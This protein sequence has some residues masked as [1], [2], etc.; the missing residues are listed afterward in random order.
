MKILKNY[1]AVFIFTSSLLVLHLR[2]S[3][4]NVGINSKGN[5]PSANAVLDLRTGNR[6]SALGFLPNEVSLSATNSAS[7]F[8][9]PDTG[10]VVYNYATAG[11]APNN[12]VPG[13]YYWTGSAWVMMLA[14]GVGTSGQVLTS[15]GGG[16]P[17][18]TTI[19]TNSGWSLTGNSGTTVG[20]NFI[21][22]TDAQPLEFKVNGQKSGYIDYSSSLANT[23]L[24]YQALSNNTTGLNNTALGYQALQDNTTRANNSAFGAY[25]LQGNT[26]VANSAF[27]SLALY[28]NTS[29]QQNIA[30]GENAG[31]A[32]TTGNYNS[33]MGVFSGITNTT[34]NNNTFIGYSADAASTGLT[35]ATA[36]GYNATVSA[37]NTMVF[38]NNSVTATE[39]NGALMPYYSSA[40]NAGASGQV[41]TS[42]GTGAA[43]QW[44]TPTAT[45]YTA[46][47]GIKISNDTISNTQSSG[48]VNYVGTS[49]LGLNSGRG[50]TGTSEGTSS[51]LYNTFIGDSAGNDITYGTNN[52]GI[53]YR[54]L[55]SND[56]AYNLVAIG[57]GAMANLYYNAPYTFGDVA[58][59]EEAMGASTNTGGNVAIG[60]QS[61]YYGGYTENTAVGYQAMYNDN[62]SSANS[63]FGYQA[64]YNSDG[65]GNGNNSTFGYQALHNGTSGAYNSALGAQAG[66]GNTTGNQNVFMGY[67]A[68]Y[69]N[70]G[71][72][73]DVA[74]GYQSLY[75]DDATGNN[76]A[77]G[78]QALYSN[79]NGVNNLAEGY[80]AM[81]SNTT[82]SYNIAFGDSAIGGS[83]S[84]A[85]NIAIGSQAL[86][87]NGSGSNNIA[88]GNKALQNN[89]NASGNIVIGADALSQVSTDGPFTGEVVIGYQ[90]L[91]GAN[92]AGNDVAIGYQAENSGFGSNTVALGY[93]ALYANNGSGNTG[94]GFLAGATNLG[95]F[96]T[97][98]GSNADDL[99]G[100]TN[101]TAIGH[102]A[103]VSTNNT[104]VFGDN[105]VT[106]TEFN[107]A[108]MPYYSNTYNAGTSGQVLESQGAGVAPQWTSVNLGTGAVN[109]VGTSYLGVTSGRGSTGTS[110]GTSSNLYNIDIGNYAGNGNTTGSY[111]IATGDSAMAGSAN[112]GSMNIATGSQT[113]YNNSTGSYNIASGFQAMQNN[114]TGSDNIAIGNLALNASTNPSNIIAI[115]TDALSQAGTYSVVA[116]LAI[117]YQA[118]SSTNLSVDD[119]AIGYQAEGNASDISNTTAVGYK[120]LYNNKSADNSALG[121]QAGLTSI[122]GTENTFIGS[123]SDV[124]TDGFTNATAIGYNAKVSASN[125]VLL[126]N[127]SVTSTEF[128]G[129]LMPYYSSAF[130][131]GTSG[132][133]LQSQGTGV[134]PQ[135]VTASSGL[136]A[137]RYV[138][139]S[140]LGLNSGYGATGTNEG[141]GYSDLNNVDI[142]DSAG[143]YNLNS[144][145]NIAIG[146][147]ALLND[148]QLNKMVAI[149]TDALAAVRN[150][151]VT[152]D[153]DIAIGYQADMYND[154]S[155]GN[156]AIGYQSQLMINGGVGSNNTSVGYKTLYNCE[157]NGNSIFGYQ[158]LSGGTS[159]N[160]YDCAFGFQSLQNDNGG[161]N[162]AFGYYAA[163][164][165]SSGTNNVAMGNSALS[166]NKTGSNNIAIGSG[167]LL[168]NSL[169]PSGEIAIGSDAL[170]NVSTGLSGDVVIGYQAMGSSYSSDNTLVGYQAATSA[171]NIANDA[172]VGY[173]VLYN[174]AGG[175]NAALGYQAG[176]TVNGGSNN[177]LLGNQA[178]VASGG[179]NNATAIGSGATVSTSN[180]VLL[181]SNSVTATEFNG[182]LM[183]YYSSAFNAGTSGQVLESKGAGVAPQWVTPTSGTVTGSGTSTQIA[184][185][186]GSS[187]LSSNSNLYWDNTNDRLGIGTSSPTA[188]LH[189]IAS[190]AKTANYYGTILSNTATSSTASIIK[191]ALNL[192]STGSWTGSSAENIGLYVSSTTG[193]AY[194]FDAIFNGGG[195]VGIG[196]AYPTAILHTVASG[197]K[198]ADY[199]GN[200][201]TNTATSSTASITKAG[202]EVQS[203][204]SWTGSSA[205]NIALYVSSTTGGTNNYDA[206]FN[207]GGNVGIGTL[208]PT[209]ILHTVAS[210]AKTANYSGNL[211]TNAA[212]SSTA[213]ITKAGL[214]IQST[215]SWTGSSASNIGI[216]VSSVTGGTS[217]YDAIFN[218]GGNVGIGTTS[219]STPLE[220]V[221]TN[222]YMAEF[223]NSNTVGTWFVM[224]NT[225]TGGIPWNI[226]ST[227]SAN[228]EGA[229][230]LLIRDNSA[231]RMILQS[232]TGYVGIGTSSP[233][234]LLYVTG[235]TGSGGYIATVANTTNASNA[236]S[237]G[238]NILA[239]AN[240]Y[241]SGSTNFVSCKT[242]NGTQIGSIN[243]S[244]TTSVSFNTTS[245]ERLKENIIP[246]KYGIN[247]LMKIQIKDYNYIG[248]KTGA[249]QTGYLAQQLY[250]VFPNAVHVGGAD[251][252]TDPWMVDY[253]RITPLLV[254]S[255]QDQQQIIDEQNKKL[256]SYQQQMTAQQQQIDELKKA[257]EQL[258]QNKK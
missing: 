101:S 81:Y 250:T 43:P 63:V 165:N 34:G 255:I 27:G 143:Y 95:T 177:T 115:G 188:A 152:G 23:S 41:L 70:R 162:C 254:K 180:T 98:L 24:G 178:D 111:N 20:T 18:W 75:N 137:V 169:N 50:S 129:A 221:G 32:N 65:T 168:S 130:Q 117:G 121:Y 5:K 225:T 74:I 53:G 92:V 215:G 207:G 38:G 133:I 163:Q 213:S 219:P 68:G 173:Q 93:Q 212:T 159:G 153:G 252:K 29:G 72:S 187:A 94:V 87:N 30:F 174:D 157:S 124:S 147:G 89:P 12:V 149:G 232:S 145:G 104:M 240:S 171:G 201:L 224:N 109:Y 132:Q 90:A 10:L 17:S 16:A 122:S 217:N 139:T 229:G 182:A 82:G 97:F 228:S 66:F 60:Y 197:A 176:H 126:G 46:G 131:A 179:L 251:A 148:D 85:L 37:S 186:S 156:I 123:G 28:S 192:Q 1:L 3:A 80:L 236:P 96:N 42:Q 195:N 204:G 216:Y 69:T 6:G 161:S 200:I 107:G 218:G 22:T 125:T 237:N 4:Q 184:F 7:P 26:G 172:G 175:G 108:L 223:Q 14:P 88:I 21:G 203:T 57:N 222:Q 244:S 211:L 231:V 142:G 71:A 196:I 13:Y 239:G 84:G 44:V 67:Q 8:T 140:Y 86:F 199:Y 220:V 138:G 190:G 151:S 78:Y 256:D 61:L 141:N 233:T 119:V 2:M 51:N 39:F 47:T 116:S 114:Y 158:A 164:Q 160:G 77:L 45:A 185:W 146:R 191:A 100:D 247:D 214:E 110:E 235:S 136:G 202:L 25:A 257:V 118:L 76:S 9:T 40:Y 226:I 243:Q 31:N 167:A 206:I 134:A 194:N 189:T 155:G 183:P 103:K 102:N 113:L 58:I 54:A 241:T 64:S 245:D 91:G 208:S 238:I 127:S 106:A 15:N 83:N 242:P 209:S 234:T 59:G 210:G 253:G 36:I 112:T 181:G 19:S 35:N 248:D 52:I 120:T 246:T 150:G 230:N 33:Y 227:G 249:Q 144:T 170:A 56:F 258:Q 128:N 205:N 11:T 79:T 48:A 73:N 49:Y 99:N 166:G 198:T 62:G 135:W 55:K 105:Y 193:G 154:F